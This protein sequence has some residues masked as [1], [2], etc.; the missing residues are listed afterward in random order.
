MFSYT[1][2]E[3]V[4]E[5]LNLRDKDSCID[6]MKEAYLKLSIYLQEQLKVFSV[7]MLVNDLCDFLFR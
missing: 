3:H 1:F 2:H 6:W 4:T 5:L 7:Q